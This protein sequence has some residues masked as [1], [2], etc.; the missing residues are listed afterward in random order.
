MNLRRSLASLAL[1]CAFLVPAQAGTAAYFSPNGGGADAVA[2]K[3]DTAQQ[4]IDVA[5]YSI[6]TSDSSPIFR[7]LKNA[8]QQR[9]VR[10][11][12][13]LNAATKANKSKA[14]ALEKIGAHVFY[15]TNTLHEKFSIIDAQSWTRRT[16]TNGSANWSSSA[17]TVYS[18]NTVIFDGWR[19]H[20]L[21]HAFQTEFNFLLTKARSFSAD[22][23]Q[24]RDPVEFKPWKYGASEFEA[25]FTSANSGSGSATATGAVNGR[26]ADAIRA[27]KRSIIIDVAHFDSKPIADALIETV[28]AAR[29]AGKP[30]E[31]EVLLEQGELGPGGQA[32]RIEAARIPVRYK[33]YSLTYTHPQAQLMHHKTT[34]VDGEVM[35]TGSYNYSKTA[36]F[37]NYENAIVVGKREQALI[38]AFL[39]EHKR[40][41]DGGRDLYPRFLSVLRAPKGSKDYRRYVPVHFNTDYHRGFMA[42]TRLEVEPIYFGF[43]DSTGINSK[44]SARIWDR[45]LDQEY[46]APSGMSLDDFVAQL[47]AEQGTFLEPKGGANAPSAGLSGALGNQ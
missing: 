19:N 14:Q 18:E 40:L 43:T 11:R 37:S 35:V 9:N 17:D 29:A 45:E 2:A 7:A 34:I 23:D 6:S 4:S 44:R 30:L 31:V 12:V 3:L 39:A 15:T 36:E 13:I 24:H 47:I 25:V 5:M 38:D 27:A 32:R 16:L 20:Q 41:W 46:R 26:I 1:T 33:Y 28:L 22:A 21:I 42:L 10:V 8:I